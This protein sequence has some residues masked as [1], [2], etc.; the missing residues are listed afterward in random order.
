MAVGSAVTKWRHY[1]RGHHF[2]IKTDHESINFFLEQKITTGLQQKWMMKLLGFNYDI[3]YKKGVDNKFAD[4]LSRRA[5]PPTALQ[6]ITLSKPVWIQDIANSYEN[7]PKAQQLIS[8]LLVSP[9]ATPNFSYQQEILRQLITWPNFIFI[10]QRCNKTSSLWDF[11][12]GLPKSEHKD[13]ILV[14]VDRLTKYS[15]FIG[16]QH[17]YTAV[18]V[19]KAFLHH[20]FKLHGLPPPSPLTGTRSSQALY[21]YDAPNLAF[22]TTVTTSVATVEEYLTHKNVML[23]ILK[24]S[25]STAQ[26]RMKFFADQ[27]RT[28]RS[29]TV[30]DMVYLKIQPY[31]QAY[32]SLRKNFKLSAKYYGPFPILAKIESAH[33]PSPTLPL[34]DHAGQVIITHISVLDY[35][36]ITIG[37]H[38]IQQ[39]L[40]HWSNA[41]AA[42]ATWEDTATIQAHFPTFFLE[43]KDN[44]KG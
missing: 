17:P 27:K 35:I 42:E 37:D 36:T 26:A 18:I 9:S 32:V 10:G 20:I 3:Q 8:Q 34:V 44:L 39:A 29:F 6:D 2:T 13:V 28:E 12:E 15:H 33:V 41:T 7:D 4:A 21:G 1:L 30:G 25:L 23:D 24:E 19:A 22:P 40:I 16:L 5:H 11:I 38:T 31:R 43:D 14:V